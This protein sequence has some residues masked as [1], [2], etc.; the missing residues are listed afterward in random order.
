[1][2]AQF[3]V[4]LGYGEGPGPGALD[5]PKL[6]EKLNVALF[7]KTCRMLKQCS[8]AFASSHICCAHLKLRL[9]MKGGGGK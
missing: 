4:G 5:L 2:E 6:D 8:L 7:P 3:V 9:D 1:M